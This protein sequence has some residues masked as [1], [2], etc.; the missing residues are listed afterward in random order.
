[1]IQAKLTGDLMMDN[2]DVETAVEETDLWRCTVCGRIGTV[3]R[4]CG[5]DTRERVSMGSLQAE[6]EK[7]RAE[8]EYEYEVWQGDDFQAGGLAPDYASA[9]SEANHYAM[10]YAQDGSVEVRIYEKH[11]LSIAQQPAVVDG[12]DAQAATDAAI[13]ERLG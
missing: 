12:S 3:G 5:E 11:L 6:I 13:R 2:V 9:Q 8:V 1:M 4:C 7:L 10:M